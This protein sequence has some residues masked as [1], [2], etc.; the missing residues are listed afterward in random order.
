M[1]K[2][3]GCIVKSSDF[4]KL[5]E[6]CAKIAN[7]S[8]SDTDSESDGSKSD[9][10]SEESSEDLWE[11]N[12]KK[13]LKK[14][15]DR[16]KKIYSFNTVDG[17]VDT[18]LQ[19]E[20]DSPKARTIKDEEI[21]KA[22][23]LK[24]IHRLGRMYELSNKQI[25][26]HVP[27]INNLTT[28]QLLPLDHHWDEQQQRWQK[29]RDGGYVQLKPIG[30]LK[31]D[32][33]QVSAFGDPENP[34]MLYWR[35]N[36][37]LGHR[38]QAAKKIN[39][40][41]EKS[42]TEPV[43]SYNYSPDRT[44]GGKTGKGS[45]G[46]YKVDGMVDG[47][48][49]QA[50]DSQEMLGDGFDYETSEGHPHNMYWENKAY[51]KFIRKNYFEAY[52]LKNESWLLQ[53]NEYTDYNKPTELKTHDGNKTAPSTVIVPDKVH[54]SAT[55]HTEGIGYWQ[56]NN[57]REANYGGLGYYRRKE[58]GE[59]EETTGYEAKSAN[60]K[61]LFNKRL[62]KINKKD[63]KA[64]EKVTTLHAEINKR[65]EDEKFPAAQVIKTTSPNFNSEFAFRENKRVIKDY[66]TP[67]GTPYYLS[68]DESE[69]DLEG[70]YFEGE[71]LTPSNSGTLSFIKSVNNYS[72]AKN[73]STVTKL[74]IEFSTLWRRRRK[75]ATKNK[76][77]S[78]KNKSS[79]VTKKD[80]PKKSTS[81]ST[82]KEKKSHS[83][84]DAEKKSKPTGLS[85]VG[86]KT[87]SPIYSTQLNP[88]D[89][90][91]AA[92]GGELNSFKKWVALGSSID[93]P[94]SKKQTAMHVAAK[95]GHGDL[96]DFLLKQKSHKNMLRAKDDEKR[97]P[98]MI[99]A[100]AG[101]RDLV[102]KFME[103]DDDPRNLVIKDKDGKT[104]ISLANK[105]GNKK[106]AED[107]GEYYDQGFSITSKDWSTF[108]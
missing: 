42:K 27:G 44:Y 5:L 94:D 1:I 81:A 100:A 86:K 53:V 89:V 21:K 3:N 58:D 8:N 59:Y 80:A 45:T 69:E 61:D 85:N 41:A 34:S 56:F 72:D 49:I 22:R 10:S 98:L 92:R 102:D 15:F 33:T 12:H 51:G 18:I 47:H 24:M 105:S 88:V 64:K 31:K 19:Y 20:E 54:V 63:N 67:P 37:Q 40:N 73:E 16:E 50:Q 68:P 108:T 99:A 23:K 91:K 83:I 35:D 57:K 2:I 65:P 95:F 30:M 38:Y 11:N 75:E 43:Y 103:A 13:L 96:I 36:R 82:P 26:V 39:R 25:A 74:T 79:G 84:G 93:V 104:A 9:E 48:S 87:S 90:M 101:N 14:W 52:A 78:A 77:G 60:F 70:V 55:R 28:D 107:L 66:K 106:L 46:A 62:G 32:E 7:E 17:L 4:D 6:L 97:T 29:R 76:S 71:E